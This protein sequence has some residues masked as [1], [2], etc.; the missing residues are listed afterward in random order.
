VKVLL[1]EF[2]LKSKVI[3]YVKDE[4]ANLNSFITVLT[5]VMSCEPFHCFSHLLVFV[6]VMLCQRQ[7]ATNEAKVG[8][9]V[10][11]VNLKDA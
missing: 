4:G 3:T 11:E 9:S 6:L 10:N 1:V 7:Y 8:A 2:N 5:F